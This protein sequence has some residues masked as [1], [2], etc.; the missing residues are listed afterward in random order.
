MKDWIVTESDRELF[1]RE[2]DSFVPNVIFDAHAHWYRAD[3]FPTDAMP[4]LVKS[5]PP[6]VGSEVFDD[7]ITQ[8]IPNRRTEG[9]FFGY[10]HA[11]VNLDA[12]NE[13]LHQELLRRPGSRGQMLITPSQDPE[14]IR[15]TVRR[16]GFVGLKC[17]HVYSPRRPTFDSVIEEYLP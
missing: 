3:H 7:A 2:L 13:F 8:L 6:I 11:Q 1:D 9:L 14:F 15:Q 16:C 17:Y 12:E 5:G 4:G 10:P